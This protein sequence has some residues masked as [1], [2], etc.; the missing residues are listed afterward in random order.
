M[1]EIN[2]PQVLSWESVLGVES[3]MKKIFLL[4]K[5]LPSWIIYF[6]NIVLILLIIIPVAISQALRFVEEFQPAFLVGPTIVSIIIGS[7]L[8]RSVLLKRALRKKSE[9]FRAM[10]DLA[11][12]F[13]YLRSIDGQYEYVSPYCIKLTGYNEQD[14]YSTPNLMDRIIHP[15]D[16]DIWKNHVHRMNNNGE[17]ESFDIRLISK[18]GGT[19]W[20]NHTCMPVSNNKG[21]QTGV[22]ST[23]LDISLRKQAEEQFNRA[24]KMQALGKLTGGIAHDYNNL[25]GIITGYAELLED[26]LGDYPELEKYAQNIANASWRGAKLTSKLLNFSRQKNS[27]ADSTDINSLLVNTQHMLEKTLTVRI[28]LELNLASNIWPVWLDGSDLEDAVLNMSINAMHAIEGNGLLKIE[29]SNQ[30]VSLLDAKLLGL[31]AGE[32]VLLSLTDNGKGMDAQTKEKIFDPFFSTKG[33]QGTGLGLSQVY[34]FIERSNGAISLFSE[35]GHGT[36][37]ALYFPRYHESGAKEP[38]V[39][40]SNTPET[41]YNGTETILVVDD[42]TELC[43][44]IY[45]ILSPYGFNVIQAESAKKALAIL[46]HK[47]I[48]LL[49]SDIIMPEMNGYQLAAIVKEKYPEIIIQLI[50][51]FSDDSDAGLVDEELQ[52]NILDKPF[53]SLTLLTR[54]KQLLKEA[55]D[56]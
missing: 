22:R 54:I 9:Q 33:D 23:N 25:L 14:F 55:N 8:A 16:V 26:E 19:V 7:L 42:E 44:I 43:S 17:H 39:E 10:V 40:K 49:F 24:Q 46:E 1:R 11:H 15:D 45:E 35:P 18:E 47:T 38:L 27:T 2:V 51:G 13:A 52:K 48:D 21:V 34:G 31:S 56:R 3:V 50:S 6:T 36:R 41:D 30:T 20:I 37:F 29:T 53:S 32:Y 28:K 12:E 4:D 5:E